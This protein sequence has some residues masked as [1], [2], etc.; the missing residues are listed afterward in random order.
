M[1][2]KSESA[3]GGEEE[4]HE[5][6]G[7]IGF[8]RVTI[9]GYGGGQFQNFFGSDLDNHM[10]CMRLRISTGVRRRGTGQHWF[11]ERDRIIDVDMTSAQF[12]ELLTT[13]NVGS[14]V[15]C[16]IRWL[17]GKSVAFPPAA[18]TSASKSQ[19]EFE[20]KVEEIAKDAKGLV[21]RLNALLE[22]RSSLTKA[23]VREIAHDLTMV[24]QAIEKNLPFSLTT[25]R[26][27]I[28][29]VVQEAKAEVDAFVSNAV[30]T[31]GV[32]ALAVGN[33]MPKALLG[34]GGP[35]KDGDESP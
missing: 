9:G 12:A 22:P 14:G 7:M 4:T 24:V 26:E 35:S 29:D 8:T 1:T 6:Y 15:P 18:K 23:S 13:A 27:A 20:E 28:Q 11:H 2:K 33:L 34:S 21:E 10:S 5:S 19:E 3:L 25:F 31:A 30:V 16:T 17:N 32:E